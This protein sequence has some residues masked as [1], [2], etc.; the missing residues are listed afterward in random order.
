MQKNKNGP[1]VFGA[2]MTVFAGEAAV[3][4]YKFRYPVKDGVVFDTIAKNALY[5]LIKKGD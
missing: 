3:W 2:A 1:S 4:A 5:K